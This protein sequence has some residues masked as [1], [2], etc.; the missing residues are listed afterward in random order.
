M[1]SCKLSGGG[2]SPTGARITPLKTVNENS[3]VCSHCAMQKRQ[4]I[5]VQPERRL[6]IACQNDVEGEVKICCSQ[7]VTRSNISSDF[8]RLGFFGLRM[9]SME[10][11]A[12]GSQELYDSIRWLWRTRRVSKFWKCPT[13]TSCSTS[14][15]CTL[16]SLVI[17]SFKL[18][19][20]VGARLSTSTCDQRPVRTGLLGRV[21]SS[22]KH[23]S[24]LA[25]GRVGSSFITSVVGLPTPFGRAMIWQARAT[26]HAVN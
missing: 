4:P 14:R 18:T 11:P 12:P 22:D 2:G 17:Y 5:R 25:P 23:L 26:L 9:S 16:C 20:Y 21:R 10:C 19:G 8:W 3:S 24:R 1:C 15:S 6:A 7:V 13:I